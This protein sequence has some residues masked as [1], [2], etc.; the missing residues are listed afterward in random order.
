MP[1]SYCTVSGKLVGTDGRALEG[2]IVKYILADPPKT[3]D[4]NTTAVGWERGQ[5]ETDKNGSFS[6][7]VIQGIRLQV[8][9]ESIQYNRV[10]TVPAT[11]TATL[12][13]L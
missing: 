3:V 5:A 10:I 7:R 12:F 8:T 6:F 4:A 1:L 2:A 13:K 11:T 9:I